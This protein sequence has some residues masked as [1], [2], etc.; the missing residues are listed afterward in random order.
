[1]AKTTTIL[2]STGSIFHLP[3]ADQFRAAR[4][5]G[6]DGIELLLGPELAD[7]A[8]GRFSSLAER[9][10][11][12]IRCV[13][14]PFF[15]QSGLEEDYFR[16]IEQTIELAQAVNAA[17]VNAH[18]F[19][20]V[21]QPEQAR[22]LVELAGDITLST[23]NMPQ[24][25]DISNAAEAPLIHDHEALNEFAR[26]NGLKMTYD[27]THFATWNT[28]ILSGYR[29]FESN[30]IN[31]HVSDYIAGYQHMLPGRGELPLQELLRMA[32]AGGAASGLGGAVALS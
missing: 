22:R 26:A 19:G 1:M 15:A 6:F 28:N 18:P 21:S 9:H 8:Y 17:M 20:L 30:L 25:I 5:S 2:L 14:A 23:E 4:E 3:L 29:L 10:G 16:E 32:G 7:V 24:G 31:I 13:H 12:P 11:V 27:V